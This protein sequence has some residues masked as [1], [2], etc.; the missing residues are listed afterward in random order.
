MTGR[1]GTASARKHRAFAVRTWTAG[2]AAVIALATLL[3][4]SGD[5][6]TQ[7]APPAGPLAASEPEPNAVLA[8]TPDRISLA[9]TEPVDLQSASIR[10]L[11]AGGS[12]ILLGHVQGDNAVANRISARP[13]GTLGLGDYI[14]IWSANQ[15]TTARFSLAPTR[16]AAESR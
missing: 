14:V 8:T 15:R 1:D 12:E 2:L 3:G 13:Q 11:R 16:S 5:A 4:S 7:S 9:F 6:P 10:V